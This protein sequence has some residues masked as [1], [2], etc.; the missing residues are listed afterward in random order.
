MIVKKST[1]AI[2]LMKEFLALE[3]AGGILLIAAT[4]IA[5]LMANIPAALKAYDWFLALDLTITLGGLGVDKPLLLWINDALMVFFFMLVGLEL[6]REVVEGQRGSR[7]P[8]CAS[9]GLT[10]VLLRHQRWPSP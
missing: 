5:L 1:K 3:S 8:G 6:K 9:R 10:G 2:D 7:R 4:V